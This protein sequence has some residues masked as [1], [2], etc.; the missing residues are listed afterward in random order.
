MKA[1]S[2]F[3]ETSDPREP[4]ATGT[5]LPMSLFIAKPPRLN[6]YSSVYYTVQYNM[7][8]DVTC[9]VVYDSQL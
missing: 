4:F 5:A 3:A 8:V 7:P 2:A 6:M 9:Q 1:A